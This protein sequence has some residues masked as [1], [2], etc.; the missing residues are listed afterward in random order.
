MGR[1]ATNEHEA[2]DLRLNKVL[3]LEG[4]DNCYTKSERELDFSLNHAE[5]IL[6]SSIDL[7]VKKDIPASDFKFNGT[8][9]TV[10]IDS[11]EYSGTLSL[12][13]T[14]NLKPESLIYLISLGLKVGYPEA[15]T[16]ESK[17]AKYLALHNGN[18]YV[19]IPCNLEPQIG[20]AFYCI[21]EKV[22]QNELEFVILPSEGDDFAFKFKMEGNNLTIQQ[23]NTCKYFNLSVSKDLS[24]ID[25]TTYY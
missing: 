1:F 9:F 19:R 8:A 11:K 2:Q 17:G 25:S 7:P 20:G 23:F 3:E 13:W 6:V 5:L 4:M 16:Y 15:W 10:F 14:L 24:S 21:T 18:S 12:K 22:M